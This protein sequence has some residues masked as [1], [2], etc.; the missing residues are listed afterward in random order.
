MV[1]KQAL[2]DQTRAMANYTAAAINVMIAASAMI[3][4]SILF[5]LTSFAV[6]RNYYSIALLKVL[7]YSRRE[8][9]SMILNSYF[10]YSLVAYALSVPIT[11][12][13]LKGWCRCSSGFGMVSPS[14][15]TR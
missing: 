3:A 4:A 6:E 1:S 8:V 15:S 2:I 9:N 13:V 10:F 14:N 11:L 12:V 5:A 7:G